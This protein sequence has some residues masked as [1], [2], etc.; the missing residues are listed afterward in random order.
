MQNKI[1]LILKKKR[2]AKTRFSFILKKV[3]VGRKVTTY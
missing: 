3:Y 2:E 1:I